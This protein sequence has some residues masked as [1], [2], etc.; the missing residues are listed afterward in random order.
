MIFDEKH[1]VPILK[2]KR[3]EQKALELIPASYKQEFTP[4]IEILPMPYDFEKQVYKKSIDYHLKGIGKILVDSWGNSNPM[5]LDL[6]WLDKSWRM[7]NGKHPLEFILNE[8]R[9]KGINLIPVVGTKRDSAYLLEAKKANT[10]DNLGICIR[11]EDQDFFDIN[12]KIVHLMGLLGIRP[13]DVDLI[14]DFKY[15]S[16]D[17]DYKNL[18]TIFTILNSIHQ[19]KDFRNVIFSS[20]SFPPNVSGLPNNKISPISRSEWKIWSDLYNK[21]G[22]LPR[23]PVFSD[24]A[25]S[26]PF[27]IE[28]DPRLMDKTVNIRYTI[29][30]NWLISKGRSVKKY[31]YGQSHFLSKLITAHHSYC[32]RNFSWGDEYI[33]DCA[34]GMN[35]PGNSETWRRVGTNHHITFVLH[36]ISSLT[37][38]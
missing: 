27:Y 12:N 36:Q 7:Y 3:G 38:I 31:G 10:I 37:V 28:L 23:L 14:I 15:I 29:D 34:N 4:V 30:K 13:S 21:K 22:T 9:K 26:N 35:G 32:G 24:Y 5:F 17:D 33:E 8:A 11:L 25:I 1:Y 19:I 20:T 18:L 16:P 6:L 2:W